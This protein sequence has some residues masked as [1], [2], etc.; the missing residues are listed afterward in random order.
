[1]PT[2]SPSVPTATA[3]RSTAG[4]HD[5]S[6]PAIRKS[7]PGGWSQ[8]RYQERAERTWEDNAKAVA[9]RVADVARLI[10]PAAILV[11]GDVRAVQ[12]LRDELDPRLAG[13]VREL[14]GSRGADGS[15]D[16]VAEDARKQVAT[17]AAEE[18]VAVLDKF[19]EERGQDDR[20]AD[21]LA[22]TVAALNEAS[23]ETLLV[24]DDPDD[25]R[26]AWFSADPPLVALARADLEAYGAGNATEQGRLVDVLVRAAFLSGARVRVVPRTVLQDGVGAILRFRSDG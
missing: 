20:A 4:L 22:A 14:D 21:G 3:P 25:D 26:P 15:D 23:V 8:R 1:M 24:A 10:D 7:A 12:F 16:A 19:K 9:T 5:A 13:L 6:D 2:S 18:T 11:A 17:I